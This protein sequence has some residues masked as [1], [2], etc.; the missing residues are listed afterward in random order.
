[1]KTKLASAM[2]VVMWVL[3]NGVSYAQSEAQVQSFSPQGTV[4]TIRQVRVQFS[5][6]MAPLG[7]PR[8][9]VVPFDIQCPG[10]G[11]A[12]WADTRN[13]AYD[14]DRD[15]SAGVRCEFRLKEGL[16]TLAGVPLSGQKVFTFSTGG[17]SILSSDPYQGSQY[18]N[19]D[20]IF[21]LELDGQPTET[22]LLENVYF[23]VQG[24]GE[25]VG[26]RI[27]SG[28]ERARI[29]KAVYRYRR[30]QDHPILLIQAK[31]RFP[32][33]TKISLVWGKSV[34]TA[35]GVTNDKDQILPFIT[36][37]PFLAEM[38]CSRVNPQRDCIPIAGVHVSFSASVS[39]TDAK[40]AVL[41]GANGKVWRPQGESEGEG[42]S[43]T[44]EKRVSRISFNAP[45][46]EKSEFQIEIPAGLVDDS[47]RKL[48]N[49]D[50]FPLKFHTDEY[51]PLAKFAADFGILE[52]KADPALP[53]TLR[54]IEPAAAGR[55][56]QIEAE[57]PTIAHAELMRKH[58]YLTEK[59]RGLIYKVPTDKP[60]QALYWID[61]VHSRSW[62]DRD[63]S[64]LEPMAQGLAK[65]FTLP[66]LQGPKSFEVVGIPMPGP[67]F[68]VVEIQS[69]MLGAAL[70]GGP[71]PMVVPTTA[72]V[73]NL[74][75]HFKWGLESSLVWVTTLDTAQP[76]NGA[77]IQI[78]DCQGNRL[79]RGKTDSSGIARVE[80]FPSKSEVPQ[81]SF[82]E[83]DNGLMVSASLGNDLAFVHTSWMEGIEPWRFQLPTEYD[84]SLVAAHTVFD[85]SLFR[86]GETVHMKHI[87]RRHLTGGFGPFPEA[88]Q[89]KKLFI[90]HLGSEQKY[91][92]PLQWDANGVA[93][94]TWTIPKE[95]KLGTYQV[96]LPIAKTEW[97]K[98]ATSGSFRVEEFRVPLMKGSI[99][100]P[101][102]PQITPAHIPVDLTVSYL[103][104]GGAGQLSVK[105]RHQLEPGS[106]PQFADFD[107]FVFGN[108]VVK[109]GLFHDRGE[110]ELEKEPAKPF[111][112]K[113]TELTLDNAGAARADIAEIPAIE[114]PMQLLTEM[115]YRDPN[116]EAQ[117]V[118]TRI[119]IWPANRLIG[120]K[121]DSW[122]VSKDALKFQVAVLD[123]DGKPVAG[124]PVKVDLFSRKFYSHRK[125]LVGGFYAY[126]SYT[127]VKRVQTLCEGTTDSHGLLLCTAKTTLSGQVI[128]QATT[129][130]GANREAASNQTVW[131][132][133]KDRWWFDV[134]A[135]DRIDLLPEKKHYEPGEIARFQV[136]M[137]FREATALVTVE[138]EGIG[139]AFVKKLSGTQPIIELP[140]QGHF[141][142]NVFVSALVVRG[143]VSGVE[144]TAT[145]DLGRPAYKLGIAE[146]N[147]GW[148]AHELKV[149]V[150][151]DRPVYKIR[152]KAKVSIAVRDAEGR[153]P[154]PGS[155]VAVA[156]V[157]EGLLELS[158][159][160]S[161]N[162]LDAMMGRRGYGVQT[163]TA[164]THIVGKRHFGL[165]A[166]PTGGGGGRQTTREL[167][168]TLLLWKGR[169]VLDADG[170][171]TVEVPLN[172]SLTRFRIVAVALSGLGR[173]GVG[174]AS[175]RSTQDLTLFSGVAPLVR[176]GDRF[177]SE[178]TLHN[179]TERSLKVETT[180]RVNEVKISLKPVSVTL[181]PGESK[182]IG[183]E[184]TAPLGILSLHYEAEAR[185]DDGA[186]DRVAITQK[187]VP[188]VPVRAF[189]ATLFQVEG[190]VQ[191]PVERPADA[192]PGRGAIRVTFRPKLVDGMTGVR[193]YMLQY[194]YFCL[195]QEA[196]RAIALRDEIRWK[197]LMDRLPAY[198]DADGM[199]K[200]FPL[201]HEGSDVLTSYLLAI[202]HEAGWKIPLESRNRMLPALQGFVEGR[203]LRGTGLPTTDLSVRKVAALEALSRYGPIGSNLV[204]SFTIEPNLW[205]TSAVIDWFN[206]L[207]R[208]PGLVN[209]N[210]ALGEAGQILK[211][212]LNFQG[213]T[214]GFSTEGSDFWWWLMVSV[215]SN[216]V[217][218]ALSV[219]D[220]PD[221]KED[222]P[223]IVRGALGRQHR[224]H[225]L[226][227]VA[228]AWGVV[229]MEKFSKAF[230]N[231]PVTGNNSVS[232][233][234]KTDAVD[235][236]ASPGGKTL[237]FAWP[238]RRSELSI[239]PSATGKPWATV[240]S[241]AAIPLKQ[242]F[243][244][245]YKIAKTLTAVEQRVK[246]EWSQ[247]D[248]VRV[249]LQLESQ[250]DM[251]WVVVSDPIPGG[252]TILGTGLGLDSRLATRGEVQKGWVWPAFQERSQEAF[253]AYYQ[254][255][256]KGEW[257]VEYTLRLNNEGTFNLPPTRAEAMYSPEMFGEI[258]NATV[259]VKGNEK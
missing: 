246:G 196:S 224:G 136:R 166:L 132:A 78:H 238:P 229:A 38:H 152:E 86:A 175:I 42:K 139:E 199:A 243:S 26:I 181:G 215:D 31:Q 240:Q 174:S 53:V 164:Q 170:D 144:P 207:R 126:E 154:A 102:E 83:L 120:I 3:T 129:H 259:R 171:A 160:P 254:F 5:Q 147:V 169:I 191:M 185:A 134:Q 203:F 6:A 108:G 25:R 230:E 34:A 145:V 92:L 149:K 178:F 20:Q 156:A 158:P 27:V 257:T 40:K 214:M 251:T 113:S 62:E 9:T 95:A 157:D 36:R 79:W 138:R 206:L 258:P 249:R 176:E 75:V 137:P 91:E 111:V 117:T 107:G 183:W 76:V 140:I 94:S 97:Q 216:A 118:S 124:A 242:P 239:S 128:L 193:N 84:Q 60:T 1:M 93:E 109:E 10:K 15:L 127:E 29:L 44:G 49:A 252:A 173:F 68:Y 253:R 45:F 131:V 50:K 177:R 80:K 85:R 241:L 32:S 245:G 63:R 72:L 187:V 96:L 100:Y 153:P 110:D 172:D 236:A 77:Q 148:R 73:T 218:L 244:T 223:R 87:L 163:S 168:D 51:P 200:Y 22:S 16:K 248:I 67:G 88:K 101:S 18:V 205:P 43:E 14:F 116:G 74:S 217:R 228:N 204:S 161:W 221:W 105:F 125:R 142:P 190:P 212:R 46:P 213:T 209:R 227:T 13:W 150:T 64:V 24:L 151:T 179:S 189:Q 143:R 226:T 162:L 210:A 35:N 135:G 222:M 180:M 167:F 194:P 37:P 41:K 69:E 19:E 8:E 159:N 256:P 188:A 47:G 56:L 103:S 112:L 58:E 219:L 250:A 211:S 57:Q 141:A 104:G 21:V 59:M 202:A 237:D 225:W 106:L 130:D 195:E 192:L 89:P 123:L 220:L 184:L 65:S 146:I 182:V 12:R 2:F 201:M 4:K 39:W 17:P 54:N 98:Y 186:G 133:G 90:Q 122:T 198:L 235:W 197:K 247:G 66:K 233:R 71:K 82:H 11:T 99:R 28:D 52:A 119:P 114:K 231:V 33:S 165:K 155:E 232:L 255:V 61:K 81:C 234:G 70:L 48:S 7:D 208:T 30:K 23:T 115:E 55:Q 121:P